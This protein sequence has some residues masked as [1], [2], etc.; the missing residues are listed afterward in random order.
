M[1]KYVGS[2]EIVGRGQTVATPNTRGGVDYIASKVTLRPGDVGYVER[3]PAKM[4]YS[5]SGKGYE[6]EMYFRTAKGTFTGVG[7]SSLQFIQNGA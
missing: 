5:Q 2:A 6:S 4:V 3:G 7:M 1:F